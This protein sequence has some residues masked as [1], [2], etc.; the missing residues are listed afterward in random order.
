MLI[1]VA[2]VAV[3]VMAAGEAAAT[4]AAAGGTAAAATRAGTGPTD[5]LTVVGAGR[6]RAPTRTAFV[7]ELL[8][9]VDRVGWLGGLLRG[10]PRV[11]FGGRTQVAQQQGV[12]P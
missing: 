11:L 1:T 4:G 2:A 5:Q 6:E 7:G 8:S 3:V 12:V 10:E 9:G